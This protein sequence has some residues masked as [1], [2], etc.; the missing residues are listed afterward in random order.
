MDSCQS[1]CMYVYLIICS[2]NGLSHLTAF[3]GAIS[4]SAVQWLCKSKLSVRSLVRFEFDK[5][6]FASLLVRELSC[7]R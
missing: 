3:D 6:Q 7:P 5:Q 1:V 4:V 2:E